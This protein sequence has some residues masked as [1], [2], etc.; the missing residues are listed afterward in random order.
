MNPAHRSDSFPKTTIGWSPFRPITLVVLIGAAAFLSLTV[1]EMLTSPEPLTPLD[2]GTELLENGLIAGAMVTMAVIASETQSLRKQ[3]RRLSDRVSQAAAVQGTARREMQSV[4]K[5]PNH[6]IVSQLSQWNLSD[7][8]SDVA[9]L[10]LKGFSHKEIAR[11]RGSSSATV[12][13]QASS[14]YEKSRLPNRSEFV[15]YFLDAM[16]TPVDV[17]AARELVNADLE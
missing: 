11:L 7:A 10:M 1:V 2:M 9:L 12:R 4:A 17:P 8:E 13:Q 6:T 15:A 16:L 14:I 3:H 5:D